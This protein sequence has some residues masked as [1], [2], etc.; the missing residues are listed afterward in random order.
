MKIP[1]WLLRQCSIL[2]YVDHSCA[3]YRERRY[4]AGGKGDGKTHWDAR[5]GRW[6]RSICGEISC[7]R[8]MFSRGE[9]EKLKSMSNIAVTYSICIIDSP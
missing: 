6:R 3:S 4:A 8:I 2:F 1:S 9:R 5:D 7:P